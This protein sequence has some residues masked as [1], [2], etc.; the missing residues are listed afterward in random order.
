MDRHRG[1][2]T[3]AVVVLLTAAIVAWAAFPMSGASVSAWAAF[4]AA[5]V[6]AV[7]SVLRLLAS[8]IGTG[9]AA[10]TSRAGGALKGSLYTSV[11]ERLWRTVRSA[12]VTVPS[13]QLMIV[14]VLALEAL[15][16]RRPW[17]TAILGLVLL[18][19]LITLHLAESAARLAVFR[20]Q[21]PLIVAGICLAGISVAAA[22]LPTG[23]AGAGSGWLAV[24]AAAGAIVA[25]ALALPV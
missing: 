1:V 17:H 15:H 13:P 22:A 8:G 5:V 25:A 16:P 11:P 21:L 9:L 23:G 6:S 19:Y 18:G 24:L 4:Y 10:D 7:L 2:R 20:P 14:A 3:V 12:L